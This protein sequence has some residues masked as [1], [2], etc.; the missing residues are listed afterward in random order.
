[1]SKSLNFDIPGIY[2]ITDIIIYSGGLDMYFSLKAID[3]NML[4]L[5]SP[6]GIFWTKEHFSGAH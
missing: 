6:S 5:T 4:M 1:M 2:I 3:I